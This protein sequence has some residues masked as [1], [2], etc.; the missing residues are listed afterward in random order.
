MS[1]TAQKEQGICGKDYGPILCTSDT[2]LGQSRVPR[3]INKSN[4]GVFL[5]RFSRPEALRVGSAIIEHHI[6]IVEWL[7]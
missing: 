7:D 5:A 4:E 1:P 6:V 2:L 3:S